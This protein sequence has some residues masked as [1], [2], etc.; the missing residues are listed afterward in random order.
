MPVLIVVTARGLFAVLYCTVVSA[1]DAHAVLFCVVGP[2][3]AAGSPIC[4][5]ACCTVSF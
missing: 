2:A 4:S 5:S 3:V 1:R